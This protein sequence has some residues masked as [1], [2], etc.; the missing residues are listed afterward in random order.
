M[1]ALLLMLWLLLLIS[2][3]RKVG[4]IGTSILGLHMTTTE[5]KMS[6]AGK[7]GAACRMKSRPQ[8]CMQPAEIHDA[9]R[10]AAVG[11]RWQ[12]GQAG[13]GARGKSRG[14]VVLQ[15]VAELRNKKEQQGRPVA[16]RAR[17]AQAADLRRPKIARSNE[18]GAE[19]RSIATREKTAALRLAIGCGESRLA[20]SRQWSFD[21]LSKR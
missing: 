10:C 4:W 14:R 5:L 7:A 16:P 2:V 9:M 3:A 13:P 18:G 12:T 11:D 6:V 8:G 15:D 20:G 17:Q 1:H 21:S 19:W